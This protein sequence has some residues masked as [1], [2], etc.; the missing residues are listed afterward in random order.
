[1]NGPAVRRPSPAAALLA[2]AHDFDDREV[3]SHRVEGDLCRLTRPE[4]AARAR[5]LA[6]ALGA[7]GLAPGDRVATLAWTGH[8]HLE[9]A[10]AA[11]GCGV[12]VHALD[13]NLHPDTIVERALEHGSRMVF[14]D[15]SFM[16]LIEEIAPR[17]PAATVLVAMTDRAN[18]P[19]PPATGVLVCYEEL[20]ASGS[21]AFDWPTLD[22]KTLAALAEPG[23]DGVLAPLPHAVPT[24][25]PDG[26]QVVLSAM[27]MWQPSGWTV[28]SAAWEAGA[29]LV[30]AGPWLD[31]GSLRTLAENEGATLV[32]APPRLLQNL[33]AQIE[34]DGTRLPRLRRAVVAN[35]SACTVIALDSKRKSRAA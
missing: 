24:L 28:T 22:E 18:M 20:L 26:R 33:L 10:F 12:T 34:G 35:D 6:A 21:D 25:I 7:A 32:A 30:F 23:H 3:I 19:V 5:R 17:L 4:L 14:F 9:I 8:R 31:G 16:P 1:M 27:P 15:L 13:P 2:H 29:T 11:G